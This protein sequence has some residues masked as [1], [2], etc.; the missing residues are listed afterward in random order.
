VQNILEHNLA[1]N[2]RKI[3]Q[4]IDILNH[5][6]LRVIKRWEKIYQGRMSYRVRR[7]WTLPEGRK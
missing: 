2:G 5:F 4:T 1:S 6:Q 3:K 7:L